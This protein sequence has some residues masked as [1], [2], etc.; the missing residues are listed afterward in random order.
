[1]LYAVGGRPG[2]E[3]GGALHCARARLNE[4]ERATGAAVASDMEAAMCAIRG[5]CAPDD[6][7]VLERKQGA[8]V[9]ELSIATPLQR[10]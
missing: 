9:Y 5:Q 7:H 6:A 8:K 1:M 2:A 4:S 10:S 3:W